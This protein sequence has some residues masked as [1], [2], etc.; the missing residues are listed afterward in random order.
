MTQYSVDSEA[1]LG[2]SAAAQATM[3]RIQS[4]VGTLLGQLVSLEGTW[5]GAAASAFQA[6]VAEWR[7][8]QQ[9]VEENLGAL[10]AALGHAAHQYAEI[11]QVNA[12][13]FL[14]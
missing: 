5:T 1:V 11:E 7:T 6:A 9:R 12:R 2:T 4:E 3:G 13:L 10:T 14:R 8:T